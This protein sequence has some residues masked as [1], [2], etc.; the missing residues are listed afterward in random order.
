[1]KE[2]DVR[3]LFE[4]WFSHLTAAAEYEWRHPEYVMEMPQSR[5]RIRGRENMRAMQ[6]AYPAPPSISLRRIVGEGDVWVIEAESDYSGRVYRTVVIVEFR[7]GKIWRETRY[8]AEPFD[9]PDWR[10]RW[11]ERM[12]ES[13]APG[14]EPKPRT[15]ES[16]A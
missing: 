15:T 13:S 9:A 3:K 14:A 10:A 1:M 2:H 11:V 6:E 5:E 8:Y 4:D 12:E 16:E 7:D